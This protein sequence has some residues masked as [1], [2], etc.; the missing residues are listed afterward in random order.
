[1]VIADPAGVVLV[2]PAQPIEYEEQP[3]RDWA[4]TAEAQ[5]A[6]SEV[7]LSLAARKM[8]PS[9]VDRGHTTLFSDLQYVS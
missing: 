6:A 3:S 1:M 5:R 2:G 8:R 9:V 7:F 4:A